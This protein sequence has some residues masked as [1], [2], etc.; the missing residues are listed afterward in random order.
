MTYRQ[1]K[2]L[3]IRER[4]EFL[5]DAIRECSGN[6]SKTAR[7]LAMQPFVLKRYAKQFELVEGYGSRRS[8]PGKAA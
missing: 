6:L 2:K 4:N 3:Q 1:F 5:S 8:T 7:V